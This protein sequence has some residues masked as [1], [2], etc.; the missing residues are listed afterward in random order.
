M[1]RVR[2]YLSKF[3]AKFVCNLIQIKFGIG[4]GESNDRVKADVVLVFGGVGGG[5]DYRIALS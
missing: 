4:L 3:I 5:R 2:L 1:E